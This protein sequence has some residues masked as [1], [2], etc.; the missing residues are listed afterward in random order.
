MADQKQ[1]KRAPAVYRTIDSI[2]AEKDIRVRLLGRVIGKS[3]GTLVLDDGTGK[4]DI[5]ADETDAA[6]KDLI[7]VFARVLPLEN[8][9]E[10]RAELI[11]KM[12]KIDE[13]LYRKLTS[14]K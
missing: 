3:G 7:R 9:Y 10:L 4:A 1:F 12:D 6:E 14:E 8:G 5:V 13:E 11:Q 2:D